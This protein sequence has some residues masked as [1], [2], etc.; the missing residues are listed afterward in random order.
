MRAINHPFTITT[1]VIAILQTENKSF[2]VLRLDEYCWFDLW[3][4]KCYHCCI[5]PILI[6]PQKMCKRSNKFLELFS[7]YNSFNHIVYDSTVSSLVE[8]E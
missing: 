5:I 6:Q 2:Y 3:E 7:I 1:V 4:D 8:K